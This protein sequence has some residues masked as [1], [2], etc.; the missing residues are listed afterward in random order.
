MSIWKK[1]KHGANNFAK[2]AMPVYWAINKPGIWDT[3]RQ[4]KSSP[5]L[6]KDKKFNW[7]MVPFIGQGYTAQ[8]NLEAQQ[9]NQ[10]YMRELQNQMFNREDTS[11]G[12][13]AADLRANGLS[14]VLAAGSGA[15]SGPV[16]NSQAPQREDVSGM[17]P[18]LAMFMMSMLRTDTDVSKTLAQKDLI[19]AQTE[20]QKASLPNILANLGL[21]RANQS[22]TN[23]NANTRWRDLKISQDSFTNSSPGSLLNTMRNLQNILEYEYGDKR[24]LREPSSSKKGDPFYIPPADYWKQ[25]NSRRKK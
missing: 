13:R 5:W 7:G 19:N 3:A 9:E 1:F 15:S 18:A 17:L 12:R 24:Y 11:I 4:N 10:E 14:P 6:T 20:N 8:K 16:V 25:K 23:A 2:V 21:I 22:S